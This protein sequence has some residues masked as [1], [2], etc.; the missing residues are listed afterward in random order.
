MADNGGAKSTAKRQS[1]DEGSL[2]SIDS[3][4]SSEWN[5]KGKSKGKRVA[6]NSITIILLLGYKANTFYACE[7]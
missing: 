2:Y 4:N 6:P 3:V 5:S 1:G 7:G